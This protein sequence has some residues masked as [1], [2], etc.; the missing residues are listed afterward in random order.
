VFDGAAPSVADTVIITTRNTAPV[1]RAGADQ[2]VV[3]GAQVPLDGSASSDP[4]GTSVTYAWSFVS[5]PAGSRSAIVNPTSPTP[6]FRADRSGLYV[7]QLVVS[8]GELSSEPDTVS[9]STTNTAP[10]AQAGVDL[11]DVPVDGLV[12]LDGSASSDAD[13]H[14]LSFRW[15]L[16]LVPAGSAAALTDTSSATPTFVADRPGDYVAQLIVS[17]GLVDS[18]PDTVLVRTANRP[19]AAGA[20]TDQAVAVGATAMLDGTASTDP[21]GHPLS[22]DWAFV[23]VPEGS[24]AALVAGAPGQASFVA[25]VAGDFVVR[26]TVTDGAGGSATDDVTVHAAA[27]GRL[28][29]PA[30]LTW[31]AVQLG[32]SAQ[33]TLLVTNTGSSPLTI[34]DADATG[35]FIVDAAASSCLAGPLGA[36][37]TCELHVSF[38]PAAT[39]TR[40]GTLT[41]ES[42]APGSPHSVA[43]SGEAVGAAVTAAPSTLTFAATLVG[44]SAGPLSGVVIN[45]G[46][47]DVEI[48]VVAI[49]GDFSLSTSASDRCQVGTILAAGATCSVTATFQ[50]TVS[51]PRAGE[52]SID[53]HGAGDA[54]ILS[55]S[56]ALQGDGVPLPTVSLAVT[57]GSASEFDNDPG[58]VTL[59]RTG[60]LASPLTVRYTATGSATNGADY[61]LLSGSA[62]FEPGQAT[63]TVIVTPS[64]DTLNEGAESVTLTLVDGADYDLGAAVSGAIAIEDGFQQVTI[65]PTDATGSEVGSDTASVTISR[66]GSTSRPLTVNLLFGGTA[67]AALDYQALA[68][69]VVIPAGQ[70]SVLVVITPI[71]DALIEGVE[72]VSVTLDHGTYALANPTRATVA[73]DDN[74]T[75]QVTVEAVDAAATEGGS[76]SATFRFTRTGDV[77]DALTV[78]YA[79]SGSAVNDGAEFTPF[80]VGFLAFDAGAVT[81]DVVITAANDGVLEGAETLIVTTIDDAGYDPGAP[82]TATVTILDP[83]TPIVT[84]TVV[85]ADAS[86]AGPDPGVFRFTRTGD[87]A[88]ALTVTF[89]RTGTATNAT[90]YTNIGT[91]IVIPAGQA[92]VDRS[93]VPVNDALVEGAETVLLTLVDGAGYDLGETTSGVV[94]IADQ[95]VPTISMAVVDDTAAES[96]DQALFR[97][98]RTGDTTFSLSITVSS[99]GSTATNV[100]D[101]ASI[102]ST[103]LFPAGQATVDRPVVPVNDIRVEGPETVALTIV[104]GAHYDLGS[105]ITGTVT[106]QDQPTPIITVEA[107]DP[108]ASETGSDNGTFRF[109]R[110]GD[111]ALA[112]TVTFTRTGTAASGDYNSSA[113]GTSVTFPVGQATAEKVVTAVPDVAAEP[114]ETVTLTLTDGANYDL[115]SPATATVTITD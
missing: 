90:D 105:P 62:T 3:A 10:V 21:D 103:L 28:D 101:Y 81:A 15:S 110:A 41:I 6:V 1:A 78:R 38:T 29:A 87:H 83:P 115:G 79:V 24:T 23:S 89:S 49:S 42:D 71:P 31:P 13:G 72:T 98:S 73:I 61:A 60:S 8:D 20:G 86:E 46:A 107:I 14:P 113:V 80:L 99:L 70:A 40:I 30:D 82:A 26:L 95:P 25:D 4:D 9:V 16:L 96:G 111:T 104:D 85:D 22:F 54:T 11:L 68:S 56:I 67:T 108:S 66:A 84:L 74:A 35:D 97:F 93:I 53:A 76:D 109:T 94:T 91:S 43:L 50:P 33:R 32:G 112:L 65:V 106:I 39:G 92:S 44:Q 37:A 48:S 45:T 114:G 47:G 2:S 57:D 36:G 7:V 63:I 59:S 58:S 100:S 64:T 18:T 5:L 17:D 69:S 52:V 77:S 75:P 51:G 102:G 19:P 55:R 88:A 34:G 27:P 12:P